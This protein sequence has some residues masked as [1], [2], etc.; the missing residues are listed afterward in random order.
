MPCL[1]WV[2]S[3]GAAALLQKEKIPSLRNRIQGQEQDTSHSSAVLLP[4]FRETSQELKPAWLETVLTHC[5]YL[6][7]STA[8]TRVSLL[9]LSNTNKPLRQLPNWGQLLGEW[10][11][12]GEGTSFLRKK[13]CYFNI[14]WSEAI[15]QGSCQLHFQHSQPRTSSGIENRAWIISGLK[16]RLL[17]LRSQASARRWQGRLMFALGWGA[18]HQLPNRF[19]P[20]VQ[21]MPLEPWAQIIVLKR[22][23]TTFPSLFLNMGRKMPKG[24]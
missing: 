22:N 17:D 7:S 8:S 13:K 14:S 19:L 3:F 10:K 21:S 1:E 5:M 2:A 20:L 12:G 16:I 4:K 15:T 11:V 9:S 6:S 24:L 23:K 18:I